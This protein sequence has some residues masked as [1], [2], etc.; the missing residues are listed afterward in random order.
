MAAGTDDPHARHTTEQVD[1]LERAHALVDDAIAALDTDVLDDFE[2][3]DLAEVRRNL[4]T[5]HLWLTEVLE[6]EGH[7][8]PHEGGGPDLPSDDRQP[9]H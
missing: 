2:N 8:P 7:G 1:A 6:A 9:I 3:E 5:A 4:R